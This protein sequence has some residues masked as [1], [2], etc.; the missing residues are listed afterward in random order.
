[1]S[2]VL[3]VI[4]PFFVAESGDKFEFDPER[5]VYSL[6]KNEEFYKI[7]GDETSEI[8]SSYSSKFEISEDY[9]KT[10]IESGYLEEYNIQDK[11]E[12]PFVN[13]F[14]EIDGLID[15]YNFELNNINKDMANEPECVKLEKTTVLKNLV[16]V[17]NYLKHL[18][19]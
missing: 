12:K 15:K 7:A 8:N 1:M 4:M 10:L 13:V 2:K 5:G 18:K 11:Q 17:L 6:E 14:D 3:R 19:K 9:A 16:K